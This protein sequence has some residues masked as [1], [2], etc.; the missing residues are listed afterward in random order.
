MLVCLDIAGIL[1]RI[2]WLHYSIKPLLIP[3]LLFLLLKA[4]GDV[5]RRSLI[6]AGLLFS[7]LGDI[8]LLFDWYHP[9][10]FM[11]GLGSFLITH[12]L[13]IIYFVR[14]RA[15]ARSLLSAKPWLVVLVGLYCAVLYMVLLP[16]LGTLML[17]VLIYA[18]VIGCM[19]LASLHAYNKWMIPA[20]RYLVTGALL[21]VVSDSILAINK[22]SVP[23]PAGGALVMLSYCAAQYY[24][25]TG[26]SQIKTTNNI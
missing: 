3:A 4:G 8:F 5:Q 12:I 10:F 18:V 1:L 13:Y 15:S 16:D 6:V 14:N 20:N 26:V 25:V 22:F 21:F 24:I 19:L 7:W 23:I 9:G 2:E 11:A 17:P